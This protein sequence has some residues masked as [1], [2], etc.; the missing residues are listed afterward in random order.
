MGRIVEQARMGG[1]GGVAIP[2]GLEPATRGVEIR[3]SIQ[4]SYGT[5]L[6][7]G[8]DGRLRRASLNTTAI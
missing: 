7:A 1:V 2:A 8:D 6:N 3:Y 4:L 5:I